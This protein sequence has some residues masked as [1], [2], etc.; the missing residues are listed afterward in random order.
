M[1][2][3][4]LFNLMAK[5]SALIPALAL[6][7]SIAT[8]ESACITFYHQSEVPSELDEYRK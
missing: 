2:N 5:F 7:I 1:K 3:K 6:F 4:K 8:T